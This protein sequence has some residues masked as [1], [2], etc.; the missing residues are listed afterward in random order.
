MIGE[1]RRLGFPVEVVDLGAGFPRTMPASLAVAGRHHPAREGGVGRE[2]ELV[3]LLSVGI[4]V[5]RKGYDLL[6]P[7]LA[8]VRE[9]PWRL[10]IVGD[11]LFFSSRRRHTRFDCDW[12][13]DVCSSD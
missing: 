10:T 3:A 4:I 2:G 6:I 9:L 13:S 1:L 8:S 5:P 11:R 12:S 7:A